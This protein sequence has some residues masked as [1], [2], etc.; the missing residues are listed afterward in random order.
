MSKRPP[1]QFSESMS[2]GQRLVDDFLRFFA[3][4]ISVLQDDL[5]RLGELTP[6]F[7]TLIWGLLATIVGV[8]LTVR[9]RS[10]E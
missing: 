7:Q 2:P 6:E 9:D 3:E 8:L 1:I 5:R 10:Q 4:E